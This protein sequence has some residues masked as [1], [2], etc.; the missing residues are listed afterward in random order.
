[1][2]IAMGIMIFFCV[3][4]VII[5]NE[6]QEAQN[7]MSHIYD[8]YENILLAYAGVVVAWLLAML[9]FAALS[10]KLFGEM[11]RVIKE[12]NLTFITKQ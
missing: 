6:P 8:A 1:M 9:K 4:F 11:T 2:S 3:K 10:L 12:R 5:C 7:R